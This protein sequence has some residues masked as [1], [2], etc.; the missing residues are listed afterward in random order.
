MPLKKSKSDWF[1]VTC[2]WF[3]DC[4]SALVYTSSFLSFE[5]HNVAVTH[6]WCIMELLSVHFKYD[7]ADC[8]FFLC[9][10]DRASWYISVI[11]TNLMHC[12]SSVYFISWPLHVSVIIVP[13]QSWP[14]DSQLKSTTRTSCCIY[15]VYLLMVSYKYV[16]NLYRLIKEINWG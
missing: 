11:K 1:L 15:T 12:L 8:S 14:T 7:R 4:H 16:R 5:W 3:V 13:S 9:F 2:H 10:V 6:C